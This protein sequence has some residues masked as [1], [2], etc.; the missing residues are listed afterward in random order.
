MNTVS[1]LNGF[2]HSTD[3]LHRLEIQMVLK[4]RR[5][6]FTTANFSQTLT[7]HLHNPLLRRRMPPLPRLAA[8]AAPRRALPHHPHALR[9]PQLYPD[10]HVQHGDE[11]HG[12][13]EEHE[14]GDL[15]SVL[16]EVRHHGAPAV[17]DA[18]LLLVDDAE[19]DGLGG[20]EAEC[21]DPNNHDVADGSGELRHGVGQEGVADGHVALHGER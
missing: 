21:D 17:L 12:P 1:V 19:L 2:A 13:D 3:Y 11:S 10:E 4:G 8:V 16:E 9:L 15:E 20:G 6:L 14:R 18:V 5:K 7:Q